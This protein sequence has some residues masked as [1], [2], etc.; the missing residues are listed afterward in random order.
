MRRCIEK[1]PRS[2]VFFTSRRL[3]T[4]AVA[5]RKER[6]RGGTMMHFTTEMAAARI[7]HTGAAQAT[8]QGLAADCVPWHAAEFYAKAGLLPSRCHA[9]VKDGAASWLVR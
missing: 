5:T 3:L 6:V 7:Q 8:T 9:G 1:A 2:V 4:R